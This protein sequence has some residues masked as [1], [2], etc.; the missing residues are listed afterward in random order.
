[1]KLFLGWGGVGEGS[2]KVA[3]AYLRGVEGV[4]VKNGISLE[5]CG[6]FSKNCEYGIIDRINLETIILWLNTFSY[7]LERY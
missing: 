7:P 3:K 4:F 5:K 1:M 2:K 6:Y